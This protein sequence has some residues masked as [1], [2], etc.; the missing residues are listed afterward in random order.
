MQ[1]VPALIDCEL[2]MWDSLYIC[3]Y[4]ND[5]YLSNVICPIDT[6]QRATAG[7]SSA[8]MHTGFMA[9]CNEMPKN[10]RVTRLIELSAAAKKTLAA[11]MKYS[12]SNNVVTQM[13]GFLAEHYCQHVLSC[14]TLKQW[15]TEALKE[16]DIVACDEA[17]VDV[18]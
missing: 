11:L 4:I 12:A 16:T 14:P 9:L 10:I 8:E 1:K 7:S 5:A 3:E 13:R 15:I 17:G 18:T 2:L 6:A